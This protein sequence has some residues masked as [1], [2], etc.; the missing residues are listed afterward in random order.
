MLRGPV[1]LGQKVTSGELSGV[2]CSLTGNRRCLCGEP[3]MSSWGRALGLARTGSR[4][5][6]RGPQSRITVRNGGGARYREFPHITKRQLFEAEFISSAMWFWVLWHCWHDSD[7]VLGHFP[8]PDAS[9]W[10]DEELGI[11]P[12]DEE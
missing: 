3:D 11:P 8:W 2:H 7:A 5:L 6:T 10:T 1:V 4:L 12:D 9:Q